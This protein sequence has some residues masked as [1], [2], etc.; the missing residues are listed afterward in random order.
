MSRPTY[1][2]NS[3]AGG[4]DAKTWR[5][6]M[7]H[8]WKPLQNRALAGQYPP[9]STYKAFVAAAA[10]QEG[11]VTPQTRVFCPGS[12]AYG[13]RAYRCWKKTGHGTV[14]VHTALVRSCDVFFYNVGTPKKQLDGSDE[15]LGYRDYYFSGRQGDQHTFRGLGID[16]IHDHLSKRFWFGRRTGIELPFEAAGIVPDPA[17]KDKIFK[18]LR[19]GGIEG[20]YVCVEDGNEYWITGVKKRY[21][22]R[23]Y[24]NNPIAVEAEDVAD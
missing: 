3:F 1:D 23:R 10:L 21:S 13:R 19:K 16:R 4:V 11:L 14:D 7:K 8:E 20:N 17:Y 2:P 12:F 22:N 24:S 18:R 6:L 9:G 15:F 5:A